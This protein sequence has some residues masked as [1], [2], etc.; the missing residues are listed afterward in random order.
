M[1]K[2]LCSH[3][4]IQF[5]VD[6]FP[7]HLTQNESR[8]PIFDASLKKLWKFYP[9]WQGGE[10]DSTD[11][12]LLFLSLLNATELVDFRVA[13]LRHTD[14]EK[15]VQSNMESLYETIGHIVTIRNPRFVL[16]RFVI[17]NETKKL[18][19]VKHWLQIWQDQYA[20]F[21]NGLKDQDL[22]SRLQKREAALERLIRNPA[23][24]PER[25]S[26]LLATW[27]SEA[28]QFPE[29]TVQ[30][31]SGESIP[32]SEYWKD[33][34]QKCYRSV[35]IIQIN[36]KDLV[37]LLEHCEEYIDLGSIF[38]YQLFTTLREGLQTIDGFFG[39]AYGQTAFSILNA[40]DDVGQSNLQLLIDTAPATE[41]SRKDYPTEFAYLKA[42]MK[43][44]IASSSSSV[45]QSAQTKLIDSI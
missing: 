45:S 31:Q 34:I 28:G 39:N 21:C 10:L 22:R 9:K 33:I 26:H 35:D 32:V 43:Y 20:D 42:R 19:N 7:I 23:I 2:I 30:T 8:H 14:T 17:S 25:Y 27:A 15:I 12:Y 37:E 36:R 44:S 18:D 1:A 38:S 5:N 4:G 24:K 16:P 41:P 40:N 11:S 3:S 13:A 29:F 6:H